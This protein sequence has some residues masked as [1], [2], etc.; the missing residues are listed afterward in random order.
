M[1]PTKL[2]VYENVSPYQMRKNFKMIPLDKNAVISADA[3]ITELTN[4]LPGN[5]LR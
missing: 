3:K 2:T 1:P 4:M 5:F